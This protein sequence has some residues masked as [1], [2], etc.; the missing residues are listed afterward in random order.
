VDVPPD[1]AEYDDAELDELLYDAVLAVPDGYGEPGEDLDAPPLRAEAE[2]EA[3]AEPHTALPSKVESWRKRSATGAIL[4]GFALG[5]QQVFEPKRDEPS[6]VMETSGDPPTDLPIDADF[7]YQRPGQ[8]VVSIRPWLLDDQP[9]PGSLPGADLPGDEAPVPG[10]DRAGAPD[11]RDR[12]SSDRPAGSQGDGAD[13]PAG[14][15]GPA[16]KP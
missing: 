7:E 13:P 15:G 5:L 16:S 9:T 6:I 4:T 10:T 12:A 8:S 11:H 2:S 14:P 1:D 3:E